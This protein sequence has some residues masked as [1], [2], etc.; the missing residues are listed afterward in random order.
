MESMRGEP[1]TCRFACLGLLLAM[2]TFAATARAEVPYTPIDLARP[3]APP[4]STLLML[5][6]GGEPL[7]LW[8]LRFSVQVLGGHTALTYTEGHLTPLRI[9]DVVTASASAAVGFGVGDIG[10]TMPVNVFMGGQR[11]GKAWKATAAGDLV[12]VPR[13]SPLPPGELPIAVVLSAPITVPTGDADDFSG[14]HGFTAEPRLLF[15]AHPGRA[16][17]G[18]RPGVHLLGGQQHTP[19]GLSDRLTLRASVG[20]ELGAERRYRTEI[21]MDGALAVGDPTSAGAEFLAGLAAMPLDGLV[22]SVH[23]GLGAGDMPG[24][25]RYRVAFSIGWEGAGRA[26]RSLGDDLDG[27]GVGDRRDACPDQ[28]EDRDGHRDADGCPELDN[29]NDGLA[30]PQDACPDHAAQGAAGC[31]AGT[32]SPDLDGDGVLE[33]RCPLQPE[34]LDGY[35]DEDGCPDPDDDGDR[36]VDEKD[37]CPREAEDGRNP[38]PRDGCPR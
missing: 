21:G 8:A 20:L 29:D 23:G 6:R 17:I 14:H 35:E 9:D 4:Q 30:D 2:V 15:V 13:V 33:D 36:I 11:E 12:V 10:L 5:D 25:A 31:P 34:D 37:A 32:L 26:T 7:P 28:P 16:L 18:V 3:Q 1:N 24:V 38:E 22:V 27:D 19:D